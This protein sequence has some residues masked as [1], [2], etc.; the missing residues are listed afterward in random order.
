MKAK[1]IRIS[2]ISVLHYFKLVFRSVLFLGAV[3]LYIHERVAPVFTFAVEEARYYWPLMVIWAVYAMEMVLRFFPSDLESMG[4]QKQFRRNYIPV[5]NAPPPDRGRLDRGVVLVLLSW[6]GLNAIFG[7]LYLTGVIDWAILLLISLLY[8]ICDMVCIL[9]FCPFQTWMM[10]NKCC[11]SCRIYNWDYAMMFTPLLFVPALYTWSLLA[12]AVL[13]VVK[14]E[15]QYARHPERF[16]EVTN[17]ALRC[18]NC[19]EKLCHHKKQLQRFLK[20]HARLVRIPLPPVVATTVNRIS[21]SV[22]RL[23]EKKP[24]EKRQP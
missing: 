13:L 11:G 24:T 18:E 15:V 10:K 21:E 5:P 7:A 14:W 12:L 6:I 2:R 23:G 8:G 9:F 1:K 17:A 20:K 22:S 16:D 4:C 3:G 19:P